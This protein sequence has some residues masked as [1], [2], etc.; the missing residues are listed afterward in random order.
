VIIKCEAQPIATDFY[1]SEKL[2]NLN[3]NAMD[4]IWPDLY[5]NSR[6]ER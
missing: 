2:G 3:P 1:A 4:L 5:L 6:Y